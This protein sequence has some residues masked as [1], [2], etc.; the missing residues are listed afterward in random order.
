MK[1]TPFAHVH[2]ADCVTLDV[3]PRPT[4]VRGGIDGQELMRPRESSSAPPN[5][6]NGEDIGGV[7]R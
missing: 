6:A 3:E 4:L 1:L 5:A 2:A 7:R